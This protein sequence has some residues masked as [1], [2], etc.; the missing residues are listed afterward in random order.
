MEDDITDDEIDEIICRVITSDDVLDRIYNYRCPKVQRV[1]RE[2]TE[3]YWKNSWGLLINHPDVSN[4][5]SYEGKKSRRRF[6]VSYLLF[7]YLIVPESV[8]ANIF[9]MQN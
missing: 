7:R 2:I 5:N 4:P 8:N 9:E 6:R 1:S 3:N